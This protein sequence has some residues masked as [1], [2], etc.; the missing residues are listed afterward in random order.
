MEVVNQGDERRREREEKE[1]ERRKEISGGWGA[2][3]VVLL[4]T[5]FI[6]DTLFTECLD[7]PANG[8]PCGKVGYL[9][10]M[11]SMNIEQIVLEEEISA[12]NILRKCNFSLKLPVLQSQ[13]LCLSIPQL[14][15]IL[16][17]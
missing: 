14:T 2:L 15:V 17:W 3:F 12:T 4:S 9:L 11:H 16:Y 10:E 6:L 5:H 1:G 8:S 7:F 13:V